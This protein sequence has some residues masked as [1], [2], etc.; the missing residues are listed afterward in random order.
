[1]SR[2][3]TAKPAAKQ[4]RKPAAKPARGKAK[5]ATVAVVEKRELFGSKTHKPVRA[6]ISH[7]RRG[8]HEL[9]AAGPITVE[10]L[11][12]KLLE[13]YGI[14]AGPIDQQLAFELGTSKAHR[15]E[16]IMALNK[17]TGKLSYVA[18]FKPGSLA[19]RHAHP[20]S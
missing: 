12:A 8:I 20:T 15:A 11:K 6:P 7:A 14:T 4:S 5:Q 1:M 10:A 18:G 3:A 16:P 9:L 2:K 13:K 19:F 17:K